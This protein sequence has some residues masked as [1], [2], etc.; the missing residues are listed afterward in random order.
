MLILNAKESVMEV[1]VGQRYQHYSGKMYEIIAIGRLTESETLQEC[2]VYKGLYD[3]PN[4]G[5]NPIWIRPLSMFVE[6]VVINGTSQPR[7]I[8]LSA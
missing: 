5:K 3:D 4:F 8:C 1:K 2:V 6:E 7:F